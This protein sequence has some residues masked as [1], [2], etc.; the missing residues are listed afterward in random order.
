MSE[1]E[2]GRYD[3]GHLLRLDREDENAADRM[4]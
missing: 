3:L 1:W 4:T 2:T